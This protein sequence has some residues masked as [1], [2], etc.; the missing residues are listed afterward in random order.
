MREE[1]KKHKHLAG[2]EVNGEERMRVKRR[3]RR[4]KAMKETEKMREK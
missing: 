2:G 3:W 1:V 4:V